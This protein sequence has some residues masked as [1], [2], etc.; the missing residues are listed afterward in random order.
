MPPCSRSLAREWHG[1]AQAVVPV[2]VITASP[3]PF[4]TAASSALLG[5]AACVGII[6][7]AGK[8]NGGGGIP[9]PSPAGT[10]PHPTAEQ[11]GISSSPFH[12][13]LQPKV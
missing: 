3:L 9:A 2:I 8:A 12:F 13:W 7:S 5:S 1:D 10:S 11:F 6:G 4:L